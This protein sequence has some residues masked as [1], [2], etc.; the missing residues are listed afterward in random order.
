[1]VK[2]AFYDDTRFLTVRD[3]VF[4]EVVNN[5]DIFCL[6]LNNPNVK[7]KMNQQPPESRCPELLANYC[8]MFLRKSPQTKNLSSDEIE[9]KL[10][11][12]VSVCTI[13]DIRRCG[14]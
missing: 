3:Q 11:D 7:N 2:E 8:D 4:Q 13:D 5:T 14:D 12:V 9:K 10:E 6:E 1:M